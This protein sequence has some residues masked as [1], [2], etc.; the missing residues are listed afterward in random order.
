VPIA[1]SARADDIEHAQLLGYV[2]DERRKP[3]VPGKRPSK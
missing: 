1:L 2:S 3:G